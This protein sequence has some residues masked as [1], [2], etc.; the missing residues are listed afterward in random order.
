M[1]GVEFRRG[2]SVAEPYPRHWHDEYQ[3]C[4]ITEG[5][6]SLQYRGARHDTPA[7]SLFIVHPGEVHSNETVT[8][9]S[10]ES[11][12]IAPEMLKRFDDRCDGGDSDLPFF[13]EDVIYD[14]TLIS[15][16]RS[17]HAAEREH[18]ENLERDFLVRRLVN[19]LTSRF[20]DSPP[21]RTRIG[22]EPAVVGLVRDYIVDHHARGITL[23]EL[24]QITGLTGSHL[25][26]VF[27]N[28]LGMPPHAFLTHVRIS[29]AKALIARGMTFA[30]AAAAVGFADQSHFHRHF[31]RLMK[32]TPGEYFKDR[33]N[34]QYRSR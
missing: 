34:V 17:L 28:A 11:I 13:G 7:A 3:L 33:K 10:F 8:G 32:V 26:R 18:A 25:T 22:R 15:A 6:G 1:P 9:C 19:C 2:T 16:Y 27:S 20:S 23:C 12:Y 29:E 14:R 4:L 24:E 5:G 21:I 31:R 30:D